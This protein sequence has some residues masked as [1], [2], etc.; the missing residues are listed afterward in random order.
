M[1]LIDCGSQGGHKLI[2]IQLSKD[3]VRFHISKVARHGADTNLMYNPNLKL[4][5][6]LY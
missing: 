4:H 5:N 3:F 1:P 2:K 6:I